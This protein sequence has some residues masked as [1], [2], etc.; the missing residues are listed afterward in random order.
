M[1]PRS[2]ASP[3]ETDD[4][5]SQANIL[6]DTLSRIMNLMPRLQKLYLGFCPKTCLLKG[7]QSRFKLTYECSR[8]QVGLVE[9]TVRDVHEAGRS[10]EVELGL[11]W[12]VYNQYQDEALKDPSGRTFKVGTPHWKPG[13]R[14]ASWFPRFR[15]FMYVEDQRFDP[16]SENGHSSG[17]DVGYW[18]SM[19]SVDFDERTVYCFRAEN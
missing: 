1:G 11:P 8:Y 5:S 19:S 9:S 7:C 17:S 3:P 18:M 12:F 16:E 13:A 6:K 2:A 15:I 14:N 4:S 10:C